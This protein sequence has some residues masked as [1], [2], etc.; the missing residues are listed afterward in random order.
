MKGFI[1]QIYR[2]NTEVKPAV[3]LDRDGTI[4]EDVNYLHKPDQ[5]KILP[6]VSQAIKK[7]NNN[8][9]LVIIITN[10]PVVAK[11]LLD[12]KEMIEINNRIF[13]L[14][15][16]KEAFIDGIYSCPHHPNADLLEFRTLCKCRK[17]GIQMLKKAKKDFN[18]DLKNSYMI[19]DSTRDILAG[20]NFGVTSFAL[21]GNKKTVN[22]IDHK[23]PQR[24]FNTLS[25]AVDFIINKKAEV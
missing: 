15:K 18:V 11:G 7:L 12:I 24:F 21:K 25:D 16:I 8:N 22:A 2:N 3:F 17:P 23:L 5:I 14:F 4:I 9:L 1:K 13:D 20:N 6:K 10:Q 19:G